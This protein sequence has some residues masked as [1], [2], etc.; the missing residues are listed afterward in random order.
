MD[1][2]RLTGPAERL[3]P[4]RVVGQ[5]VLSLALIGGAVAVVFLLGPAEPPPQSEVTTETPTVEVATATPHLEGLTFAVDGV[6]R[7]YRDLNVAAESGGRVIEKSPRCRVG[8]TVSAGE[9][10]IRVDPRDYELEVRRLEEELEQAQSSAEELAVQV[11]SAEEQ[12]ALADEFLAIN[13]R[14]LRRV[15]AIR[16]PGAIT[17]S[18]LDTTRRDVVSSRISLQSQRDQLRLLTASLPRLKS[19]I[20]RTETQ[21]AVAR[22]GL[23]RCVIHAPITGVITEEHVEQDGYL[24]RGALVFTVRDTSRLDVRCSLKPA[25]LQQVWEG[26]EGGLK[27]GYEFPETPVTVVYGV[28]PRRYAWEGVLARFDGAGLDPQTRMAPCLVHVDE[29]TSVTLLSKPAG[30]ADN[31]PPTLLVG[32]FVEVR[33]HLDPGTRF[34]SIPATALHPGGRVWVVRDDRLLSVTARVADSTAETLLVYADDDGLTAG[35][36]VVVS[37]LASAS[38]GEP[39]RT[40]SRSEGVR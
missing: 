31:A 32:M 28:G 5:S 3:S 23:E 24:Q 14:E 35:D 34:L 33:V 13:R 2:P 15:E 19:V 29:P 30:D 36:E 27:S 7:P 26:V 40:A 22:L 12:I 17:E 9:V 1:Q 8:R 25:Q 6:V 16:Q 10:L 18:E 39:V 38:D 20:E 4:A 37:P 21:L 11:R